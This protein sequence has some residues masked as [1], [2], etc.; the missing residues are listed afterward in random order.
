MIVCIVLLIE[1]SLAEIAEREGGMLLVHVATISRNRATT[2]KI[3]LNI[4][5]KYNIWYTNEDNIFDNY[6][7]FPIL[8]AWFEIWNWPK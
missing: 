5:L 6:A 1:V 7:Y 4:Q 3:E 8:I 2:A